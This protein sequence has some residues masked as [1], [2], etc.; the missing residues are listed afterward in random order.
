MLGGE[1][2]RPSEL[3]SCRYQ[4]HTFPGT[5]CQSRTWNHGLPVWGF[6]DGFIIQLCATLPPN[7]PLSVSTDFYAG[8]WL[9][10]AKSPR[11]RP[12]RAEKRVISRNP[13]GDA[14]SGRAE[15]LK[16]MGAEPPRRQTPAI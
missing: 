12:R 16:G 3:E 1:G 13:P 9:V 15:F 11:S 6:D 14:A 8:L 5:C 7:N 10:H 2:S 4:L